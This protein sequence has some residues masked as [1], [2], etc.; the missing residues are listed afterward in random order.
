[1]LVGMQ[2]KH[3]DVLGE[4]V[5]VQAEALSPSDS[6]IRFNIAMIQQACFEIVSNLP[7]NKRSSADLESAIAEATEALQFVSSLFGKKKVLVTH[8]LLLATGRSK[9]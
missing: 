6:S 9:H 7:P 1:V 4:F 2:A 8:C 5:L 3:T